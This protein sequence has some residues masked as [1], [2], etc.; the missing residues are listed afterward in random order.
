MSQDITHETVVRRTDNNVSA[1]VNDQVMMM[2]LNRGA[3]YAMSG[4]AKA[5][6]DKIESPAQVGLIIEQLLEEY[7]VSAEDCERDVVSFV[8]DLVKHDLA[9]ICD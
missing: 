3:Y 8:T 5:V 2:D 7:D 9:A 1:D 4:T 6:W